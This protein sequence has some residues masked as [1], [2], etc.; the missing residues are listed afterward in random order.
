MSFKKII[1]IASLY[2]SLIVI[3]NIV[4]LFML[5]DSISQQHDFAQNKDT[6]S[7]VGLAIQTTSETKSAKARIYIDNHSVRFLDQ[8]NE[9]V[10]NTPDFKKLQTDLKKAHVPDRIIAQSEMIES[11]SAFLNTIEKTVLDTIQK[12]N[13]NKEIQK[14]LS[15][16]QYVIARDNVTNSINTFIASLN[17]WTLAEMEKSNKKVNLYF[18]LIASCN[19]LLFIASLSTLAFL[20][21]KVKPVHKLI[22]LTKEFAK[23]NLQHKPQRKKSQDEFS[24]LTNTFADM[25]EQLH[26]TLLTVTDT[27]SNLAASAEELLASTEVSN[28][29]NQQITIAT[30]QLSTDMVQQS[31]YISQST[32][33]IQYIAE[34]IQLVTTTAN[35]ASS[36]ATDSKNVT[37]DGGLSLK[38][39][40][41][42]V[43]AIRKSVE[44]TRQ[45]LGQ[46]ESRTTAIDSM[47]SAITNIADQTNLLAL[48]AA[49]EAAR[50]GE[51]GKGFAVVADEVRKLAEQSNASA[52]EIRLTISTIHEDMTSTMQEMSETEISVTK[53]ISFFKTT[54]ESFEEIFNST[55]NMKSKTTEITDLLQTVD[56]VTGEIAQFFT[57]V[58]DLSGQTASKTQQIAALTEEQYASTQEMRASSEELSQLADGLSHHVS[59]F[60]L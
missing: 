32:R 25:H 7:E 5:K 12:D 45:A 60:K 22:Q 8:Y 43:Y 54:G 3:L 34:Q 23:G 35:Y 13:S 38:Q 31:E 15:D 40:V 28:D 51:H 39:A 21:R 42:Q 4:I 30:D 57:R 20:S 2:V 26:A 49:I 29:A 19:A 55:I 1:R 6:F 53:G 50:A 24:I 11:Q 59:A 56:Q 10:K 16:E 41:E 52:Q 36:L 47:V 14:Q 44:S 37:T 9:A 48:N 18:I 58:E 33:S 27:S 46:L 17:K